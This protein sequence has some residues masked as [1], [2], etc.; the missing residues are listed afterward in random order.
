MV[1]FIPCHDHDSMY[2]CAFV[3]AFAILNNEDLL[4]SFPDDWAVEFYLP[5]LVSL[6]HQAD[7]KV[8]LS[9]GGWT[10]SQRFSSMV[11]SPEARQRFIDW[12]VNFIRDYGTD[13]VDIGKWYCD[14]D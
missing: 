11:A 7:T 13:G 10:G 14:W 3:I 4:P 5:K 2:S 8:L 9:I 6:A 12:N 1:M